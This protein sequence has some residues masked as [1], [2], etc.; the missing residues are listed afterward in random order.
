MKYL[1]LFLFFAGSRVYG[2]DTKN[3]LTIEG[4]IKTRKVYS[5]GELKKLPMVQVDSLQIYNHTM[6]LHGVTR[7][8]KG[9]L[10]KD[11]LQGV[12]FD[13]ETPKLLSEYYIVCSAADNY[14]AVF[15]WNEIF[16][17]PTGDKVMIALEKDGQPA[18]THKEGLVLV[19]PTDRATGR[20]FV[21]ECNRITIQRVN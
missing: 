15:S 18:T 11:V 19:T 7:N 9:V 4:R 12:E 6:V 16:N 3:T 13:A 17:S 14:K 1:L 10:L 21:K 8:I 20:R 2:Q 5:P